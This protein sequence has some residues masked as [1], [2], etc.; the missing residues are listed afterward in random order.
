[1]LQVFGYI[2]AFFAALGFIPYFRDIFN[3]KT[4]PQR[5]TF[6]IYS[7]LGS[8]AFF[9]QQV[10]GATNSLWLPGIMTAL[11][12]FTFLL[13]L[14]HGVGGFAKKD[15]IVLL[16]AALG[17]GVWYF[18]NEAAIALYIV[19]IIDAAGTYLTIEKA[20]K[21]PATETLSSWALRSLAAFFAFLAVGTLN[22]ILISY[23]LY[24]FLI[25]AAVVAAILLGKR[26][27]ELF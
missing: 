25:D 3:G 6:F 11:V 12:F 24:I 22:I 9:S 27:N 26:K 15:F 14:K 5:V 13:S 19:I 23:P 18:T 20:Y 10:K 4:K 17:L 21:Y 1:M 7:I 2:S 8:I 16:I